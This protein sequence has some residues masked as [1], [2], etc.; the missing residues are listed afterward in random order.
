MTTIT[1]TIKEELYEKLSNDTNWVVFIQAYTSLN[2]E[3]DL[4]LKESLDNKLQSI[5]E[6]LFYEIV[7][8]HIEDED[9]DEDEFIEEWCGGFFTIYEEMFLLF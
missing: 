7:R 8:D 6:P 2:F 9:E 1:E 3:E 5:C 4:T